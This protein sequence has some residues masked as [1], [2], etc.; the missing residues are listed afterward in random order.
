MTG[1]QIILYLVFTILGYLVQVLVVHLALVFPQRRRILEK[2]PQ[3]LRWLYLTPLMTFVGFPTFAMLW[4]Q[5]LSFVEC[6]LVYGCL[7]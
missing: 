4:L 5:I 6:C 2:S 3:L 1:H 7:C